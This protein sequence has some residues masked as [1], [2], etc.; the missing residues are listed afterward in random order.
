MRHG[1]PPSVLPWTLTIEHNEGATTPLQPSLEPIGIQTLPRR[2]SRAWTLDGREH[3]WR[4]GDSGVTQPRPS[5][6]AKPRC[7]ART[8]IAPAAVY[9]SPGVLDLTRRQRA[10]IR[11]D[12]DSL[13]RAPDRLA[14]AR[15]HFVAA[16]TC[17]SL[18]IL[19][20][21]FSVFCSLLSSRLRCTARRSAIMLKGKHLPPALLISIMR[22]RESG[23][24][25]PRRVACRHATLVSPVRTRL[26]TC[27]QLIHIGR[28]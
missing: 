21:R 19:T 16:W 3:Y 28:F 24:V 20:P 8:I 14:L 2:R 15:E 18:A 17:L 25:H 5:T 11:A 4:S 26:R 12:C 27:A 9:R 6:P 23:A 22:A 10:R 1:F 13:R 7:D